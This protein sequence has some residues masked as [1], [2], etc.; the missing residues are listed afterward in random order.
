MSGEHF[1]RIMGASWDRSQA[2]GE[3]LMKSNGTT[4]TTPTPAQMKVV[5]AKLAGFETRWIA[6]VK[7]RG[8]DG[9]A[10]LKM[11]RAEIA[12]YKVK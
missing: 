10:A 7:K 3:A 11:L 8:I 2:R 1:A 9:V 4:I 12:A 6:K 5:R